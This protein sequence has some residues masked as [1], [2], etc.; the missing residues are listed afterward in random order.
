MKLLFV[1]SLKEYQK[2]V[3]DL[4]AQAG[5]HVFSVSETTGFKDQRNEDVAMQWF[6][7]GNEQFDSIFLFSFTDVRKAEM[8]I[9]LVKKYNRESGTLF[10]VH[11][12]I[13]PVEQ[14]TNI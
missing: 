5:V 3:V 12:F 14:S 13:M 1:T 9:E 11:A 8:V 10:P 2:P 7:R 4:L 6:G